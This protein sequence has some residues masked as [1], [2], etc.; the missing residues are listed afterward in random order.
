MTTPRSVALERLAYT[1]AAPVLAV[2][3]NVYPDSPVNSVVQLAGAAGVAGW[4]LAGKRDEP[5]AGRKILRW[6]PLVLAAAVDVAAGH[7]GG[8]GPYWL[9]GLLA[10]GWAAAGSF[11]LPYSRHA[12]RRHR[13]ALAAPAPQPAPAQAEEHSPAQPDDGADQLTREARMLWE[14]AGMPARTHVVKATRH[15][16]M[17]HDLTLLLRA[18]ETGRPITGLSPEIVAA[19]FGVSAA[20]VTLTDVAI[21]PGRQGGPGWMEARIT[22]EAGA[23]RRTQPTDAER[24]IDRV[25]GPKGGAPGSE[26]VHTT[27]D[28]ERRVTFYRAKMSDST[29]SPRIDLPKVC[30]AL[31]LPEDDSCV[32]VLIDGSEFLISAFDTPPLSAIFPATREL[33][34]P[35]DKGMYVCGYTITGQ[36]VKTMVYQHDKNAAAHGLTL[37]VSRSGKTQFFAINMAAQSLAGHVVW[38]STVRKDEKTT[39]LGKYID[40]QGSNALWMARSLRAAKALCEIRAEMPWPHDGQPHDYKPGD[41]RCPYRQLNVYGDEFMTA[42]QDADFGEF[43][44]KDGDDL[45]V[46][47]LKYGIGFNPAGQSPFAHNGFSTEMKDNLRQNSRPIIFNMGSPGATRKAAEGT[48]ENAYDVPTIPARY[49]RSE[50]SAIERAMRGEAD[51]E[52]GVSTGGV[53]VIVLDNGRAVLMRSL[54]A[55]FD[56]DLSSL[57]PDEVNRLTDHEISELDKRGLWFDWNE[58]VRPGEFWPEPDEDGDDGEGRS[59]RRGGGGGGKG[60]GGRGS[61]SGN[62]RSEQIATPRQALEA[63]KSLTEA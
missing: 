61:K 37:G 19:A 59:R 38:L 52:N 2:A 6:T 50:G 23:R 41:P 4:I 36:P 28:N 8:F 53:A 20:D 39:V 7:T 45:T 9:D 55:D 18:S 63:I 33:L 57:F 40:R 35:D 26:L 62:R 58:P 15:T 27:R 46:T 17:R 3:P 48:M 49:S 24:W 32:F 13:P 25:A 60:G 21:Q 51:P 47:G 12:R 11:V 42:A 29:E 5:G 31:D 30:R 1:L 44:Q 34:T 16:A 22:P 56:T 14:R 43:I 54:Y 10:A